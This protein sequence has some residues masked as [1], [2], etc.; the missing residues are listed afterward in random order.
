MDTPDEIARKRAL[1]GI[2]ILGPEAE[3]AFLNDEARLILSK[4]TPEGAPP[5]K[6]AVEIPDSVLKLCRGGVSSNEHAGHDDPS[7]ALLSSDG[8]QF[9]V[10]ANPL[11]KPR[12][13]E[14]GDPGP[15]HAASHTPSHTPSHTMVLLE[16]YSTKRRINIGGTSER[17]GLTKREA[18]V[19]GEVLKG[20]TNREISDELYISEETV[21]DHIGNIMKKLGVR[22]RTGIF[23]EALK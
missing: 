13:M 5:G 20:L 19:V 14:D 9:L 2:L 8:T 15:S 23:Y 7:A 4:M 11:A 21:K 6:G 3:V 16:Q 22:N 17:H 18:Q 12:D 10:R 1:P